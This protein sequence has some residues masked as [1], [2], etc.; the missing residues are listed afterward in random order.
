MVSKRLN[1]KNSIYAF[2]RWWRAM[3]HNFIISFHSFLLLHTDKWTLIALPMPWKRMAQAEE[4]ISAAADNRMRVL[5]VSDYALLTHARMTEG[6]LPRRVS[7]IRLILHRKKK[8]VLFWLLSV[9]AVAVVVNHSIILS[10]STVLC[11]I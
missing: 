11:V 4:N 5:R 8:C 3:I 1:R 6:F 10:L 9:F 7:N 2:G